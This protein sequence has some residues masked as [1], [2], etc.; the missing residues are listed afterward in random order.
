MTN[1]I[2]AVLG[3][4]LPPEG[5]RETF[6]NQPAAMKDGVLTFSSEHETGQ[7][8]TSEAFGFKWGKRD[9]YSSP[10]IREASRKWLDERFGGKSVLSYL[11]D[12]DRKPIVLDAGCGAGYSASIVFQ[13]DFDRI[14]YIGADISSAANI[15]R[16]NI[17]PLASE[18]LFIRSDLTKLPFQAGSLDVIFS[19]GVLHHT[20]STKGA[21]MSLVP[22]L[23]PGGIF[24]FYVYAK[25]GAIREFTDDFLRDIFVQ[26]KPEA[27]WEAMKPITQLGIA[28]GELGAKVEVKEDIPVLGIKKGEIDVQRLFYWSVLKAY[29]RPEFSFDEM[30]H[31]NF[32]WFTPRY[33]FRQT[34]EDVRAWLEEAGLSLEHMSVEDAGIT[35]VARK[36]GAL[37]Q[38]SNALHCLVG[39]DPVYD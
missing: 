10:E 23:R 38:R 19:E 27:A 16:Q 8:Q 33:A 2:E 24:A 7:G 25:K 30:N 15:A 39:Y 13:N 37:H 14:R 4:S 34:P 20:P 29:Y 26:M 6:G 17:A 18:S 35:V 3:K 21:F 32:D 11:G 31:I 9:T 28:L 36:P 1:W 5:E 12:T 22:F